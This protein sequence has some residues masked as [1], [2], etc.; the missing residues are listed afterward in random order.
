MR[1]P[2]LMLFATLCLALPGFSQDHKISSAQRELVETERAFARY[3]V[4]NGIAEAWMEFFTDDGI[5]F[6]PGP[7]NSKEFYRKRLPTPKPLAATLNW[8]PRYGDVSQAGD[9]GYN[10]GPW[11]YVDNT[12]AKEPDA[13]GYYMSIWKKQPD[14][15]WKVALDFGTGAGVAPSADHVFG[16][17]FESA[18]H[19]KIKVPLGSNPAAEA[20]R[21][22]EMEREFV[23]RSH[24]AGALDT[25]LAQFSDDVKVMRAGQPPSG[26]E[27]VR[28]Y[29]PAGKDVSLTF[30]PDGGGVA[31]SNDFAYTYGSYELQEGGQTKEKGYYSHIW[32]RDKFGNWRIV[33]SNIEERKKKSS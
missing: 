6:V 21:L 26:K 28:T 32:R 25:Y 24:S 1:R 23:T 22:I 14:G 30:A 11:N 7:A 16:K 2:S 20:Q 10:I 9:L 15:K 13:H 8:E 17:P 18:R 5:I 3:C 33:V 12:S 29:I 19:Y 27:I 31:N 4:A